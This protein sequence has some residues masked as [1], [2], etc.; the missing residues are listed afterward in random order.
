MVTYFFLLNLFQHVLVLPLRSKSHI[1]IA[2]HFS[3]LPEVSQDIPTISLANPNPLVPTA[4]LPPSK[5]PRSLR[6]SGSK[7]LIFVPYWLEHLFSN[8]PSSAEPTVRLGNKAVI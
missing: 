4:V 5:L 3:L 7:V 2:I 1:V 6:F 8:P